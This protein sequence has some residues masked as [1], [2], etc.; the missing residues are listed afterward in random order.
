MALARQ[1]KHTVIGHGI[2]TAMQAHG[3]QYQGIVPA[4]QESFMALQAQ[5]YRAIICETC[6][7]QDPLV[8]QRSYFETV[9]GHGI[10]LGNASTR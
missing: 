8:M 10:C 7:C 1:C 4:M 9:I 3:N 5:L 2:G 6:A